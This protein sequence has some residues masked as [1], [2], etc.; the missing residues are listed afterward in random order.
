MEYKISLSF[1]SPRT[2][3]SLEIQLYLRELLTL[4]AKG[5][6]CNCSGP[7]YWVKLSKLSASVI[8]SSFAS[9]LYLWQ[10]PVNY[11]P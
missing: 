8:N 7:A 2:F 11:L 9:P 6:P 10:L 4:T 1:Y 5:L 3:H